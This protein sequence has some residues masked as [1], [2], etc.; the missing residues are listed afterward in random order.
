MALAVAPED[1][2]WMTVPFPAFRGL[3]E[4]PVVLDPS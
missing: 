1:A 4:L 2:R 3:A